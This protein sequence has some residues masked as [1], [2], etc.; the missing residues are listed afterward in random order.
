MTNNSLQSSQDMFEES[1]IGLGK[2]KY[3]E[4]KD[5]RRILTFRNN[6]DLNNHPHSPGISY[7]KL[8]VLYE[9][10]TTAVIGELMPQ[11]VSQAL[12]E[13]FDG[14]FR[15]NYQSLGLGFY[16]VSFTPVI[17]SKRLNEFLDER[18][19]EFYKKG[20]TRTYTNELMNHFGRTK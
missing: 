9:Y 8:P 3:K 18:E 19:I 6:S 4:D 17:E 7:Y 2:V 14:L 10:S 15:F 20:F 11:V 12:E 1:R 16:R 13:D 5:S